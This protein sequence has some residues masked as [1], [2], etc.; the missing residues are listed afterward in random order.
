MLSTSGGGCFPEFPER[1][2]SQTE[3]K[4]AAKPA[5]R[6]SAFLTSAAGDIGP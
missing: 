5:G 6:M 3:K 1:V 4:N 2:R